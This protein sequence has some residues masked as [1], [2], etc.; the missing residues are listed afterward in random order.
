MRGKGGGR[1][2]ALSLPF[3]F[4]GIAQGQA[5]KVRAFFLFFFMKIFDF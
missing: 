2:Y 5:I 4:Y 3:I 1:F